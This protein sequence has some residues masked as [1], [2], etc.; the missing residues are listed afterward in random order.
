MVIE[1]YN[2]AYVALSILVTLQ[3]LK[4]P[5]LSIENYFR[6]MGAEVSHQ[7]T[8]VPPIE[9]RGESWGRGRDGTRPLLESRP[10]C[11]VAVNEAEEWISS[12]YRL[13]SNKEMR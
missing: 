10:G 7:V 2:A 11:A 6:R 12:I 9:C 4:W 1:V 5:S 8:Q 3:L 13:N